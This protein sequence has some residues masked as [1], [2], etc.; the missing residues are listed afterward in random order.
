MAG[1]VGKAS[2]PQLRGLLKSQIKRNIIVIASITAVIAVAQKVF[3]NDQRKK[4]YAEFY[5]NYDIEKAF[6][7]IRNK[8]LFDSCEPDN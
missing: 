2:K 8:G 4:V 6:H 7:Q 5:K 3:I 1:E